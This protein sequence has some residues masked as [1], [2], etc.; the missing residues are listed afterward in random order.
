M[1]WKRNNLSGQEGFDRGAVLKRLRQ[2]AGRKRR[3]KISA[4][5][6]ASATYAREGGFLSHGRV[7]CMHVCCCFV[8]SVSRALLQSCVLRPRPSSRSFNSVNHTW[9][10]ASCNRSTH[11]CVRMCCARVRANQQI[12][13]HI[14]PI[15]KL[16][17]SEKCGGI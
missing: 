14:R 9:I 13:Y 3:E 15:Q 17:R 10:K 8:P 12:V 7:V 11:S 4:N 16:L 1:W 5:C 2:P 6:S